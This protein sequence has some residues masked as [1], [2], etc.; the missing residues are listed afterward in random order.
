MMKHIREMRPRIP[1]DSPDDPCRKGT[2]SCKRL[3]VGT[4]VTYARGNLLIRGYVY[5]SFDSGAWGMMH[6]Y[7][8]QGTALDFDK[9]AAAEAAINA[10][11]REI[12]FACEIGLRIIEGH[13]GRAEVT[14]VE[15]Q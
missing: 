2:C 12:S 4:P 7:P 15:D 14:F 8:C 5:E 9:E 10:T 6:I 11:I 13:H 1:N 3:P